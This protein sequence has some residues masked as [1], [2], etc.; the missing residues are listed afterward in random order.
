[1]PVSDSSYSTLGGT[2][3]KSWRS[4]KPSRSNCRSVSVSM[5]WV[6]PCIRLPI[7]A[8]RSL[9]YTPSV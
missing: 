7:S 4:T 9:P 1:M 2:S 8:W 5:R 6:T 3:S